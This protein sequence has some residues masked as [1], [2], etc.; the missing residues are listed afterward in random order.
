MLVLHINGHMKG[1]VYPLPSTIRSHKAATDPLLQ[2]FSAPQETQIPH[3]SI[4]GQPQ[5]QSPIILLSASTDL[6]LTS[7]P[8]HLSGT[9]FPWLSLLFRTQVKSRFKSSSCPLHSSQHK[10][11]VPPSSGLKNSLIKAPR[12]RPV[13]QVPT[14]L[15]AD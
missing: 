1:S 15:S 6:I 9:H 4:Q 8:M 13:S 5:V 12:A 11:S 2:V 3:H 14:A 7:R 10:A